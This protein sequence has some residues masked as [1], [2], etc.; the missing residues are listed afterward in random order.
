MYFAVPANYSAQ[1]TYSRPDAQGQKYLYLVRVLIGVYT[2][3]K[4][5]MRVAPSKTGSTGTELYD[6][7]VNDTK[8]P[9]MYVVFNDTQAYP[10]YLVTFQP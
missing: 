6:S 1:D 2:L 10:D 3:G 8:N 4:P 7:V 5:E 9:V